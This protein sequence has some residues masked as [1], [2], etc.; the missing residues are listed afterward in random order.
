MN[1]SRILFFLFFA[2]YSFFVSAHSQKYADE[3]RLFKN[4]LNNKTMFDKDAHPNLKEMQRDIEIYKELSFF[5][6]ALQYVCFL[7]HSVI[8]T[9]INMPELHGYI[10]GVCKK[11][12]I[13]TKVFGSKK[14]IY[15]G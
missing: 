13:Q 4:N 10:D 12:D 8:I 15:T 1:S 3:F 7:F 5:Q 11:N 6:R 9:P 2:S 14:I